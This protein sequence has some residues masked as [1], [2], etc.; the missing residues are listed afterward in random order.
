MTAE[1]QDWLSE[2]LRD[3]GSEKLSFIASCQEADGVDVIC[4][5]IRSILRLPIN[6]AFEFHKV[7]EA[8]NHLVEIIEDLGVTVN[9]NSVL[10]FNSHREISVND[11]RGFA[12]VDEYAPFIFVNSKDAKSAQVFTLIHE[13]SHLLLGYT[14]GVGGEEMSAVSSVE[15][16]C[17]SIAA[18]LL[19][20][21]SLLREEVVRNRENFDVLVKRF[22]VSRYVIARRMVEIGLMDK[23]RMFRLYSRWR[24]EP[25]KT[26]GQ[27]NGNFYYTAV[28]R[29]G[30]PFL[31]H[32]NNAVSSLKLQP[33]E[34]YRLSGM[35]GDTFWK[36]MNKLI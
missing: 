25:I 31:I 26:K 27:S 33:L 13:F 24:Q 20:P 30:R 21:E 8:L 1:R 11:C 36:V 3:N 29:C 18:T 4:R 28:K 10:G 14:A 5:K 2:Y 35:R 7:E 6:W 16:L 9:F 15:R 32:L 12:L 22:K 19:V 17:D 23:E 34:A